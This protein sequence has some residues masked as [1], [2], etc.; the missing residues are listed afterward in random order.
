M[1]YGFIL[2]KGETRPPHRSRC[3]LQHSTMTAR[4]IPASR[5][6]LQRLLF[7]VLG[8]DWLF[9]RAFFSLFFALHFQIRLV[10]PIQQS[11]PSSRPFSFKEKLFF[12]HDN[13]LFCLVDSIPLFGW[14]VR[15]GT[16]LCLGLRCLSGV[17]VC[18]YVWLN[19][20]ICEVCVCVVKV[21]VRVCV[22]VCV[23]V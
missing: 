12:I 14:L 21:C 8:L 9:Q 18:D 22:A 10:F 7:R 13:C 23:C 6:T 19:I 1:E 20:Y 16:V 17:C 5:T 11:L 15:L 2:G 4:V 3:P